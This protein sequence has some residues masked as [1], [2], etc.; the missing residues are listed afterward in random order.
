MSTACSHG[1]TG[2]CRAVQEGCGAELPTHLTSAI[3]VGVPI[4]AQTPSFSNVSLKCVS[5]LGDQGSCQCPGAE[6]ALETKPNK[7]H[8]MLVLLFSF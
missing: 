1:R 2:C 4:G 5:R 6:N 3:P 7:M 8:G